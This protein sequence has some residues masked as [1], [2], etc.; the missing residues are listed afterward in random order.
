M[1][2]MLLKIL[3]ERHR[4]FHHLLVQLRG[5]QQ[6]ESVVAPHGK[7]EVGN[8]ETGLVAGDGD[9]ISI[10]H[11][12][13]HGWRVLDT[14]FWDE[15]E[16]LTR[17]A[18][19][20][21]SDFSHKLRV[22]L[23]GLVTLRMLTHIIDFDGLY[24]G[25]RRIRLLDLCD[26]ARLGV[27]DYPVRKVMDTGG[28]AV[29]HPMAVTHGLQ[30]ILIIQKS[31]SLAIGTERKGSDGLHQGGAVEFICIDYQLLFVVDLKGVSHVR[32][33]QEL[34]GKEKW[35]IGGGLCCLA[36]LSKLSILIL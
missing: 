20:H 8:V 23:Q 26:D 6:M 1:R 13:P 27:F 4:L 21:L 31:K 7:T 10:V 33:I 12:L 32:H 35:E 18:L 36:S 14:R 29:D 11:S 22:G 19:F 30:D 3:V 28:I 24:L 25:K 5:I 9:D 2:G 34:T 17:E 16:L 15:A